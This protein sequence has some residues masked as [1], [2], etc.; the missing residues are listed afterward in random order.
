MHLMKTILADLNAAKQNDPA[1]RS[2]LEVLLFY[3]YMKALIPYRIAHRLYEKG[4]YIFARWLTN[5]GRRRSGIEI[6]PGAQIGNGFFIDHG[7]GVVIG[8]T[9]I[10]GNHVT[11]Y[12]GVTLGAVGNQTK[13]KRH[14]TVGD[15][16]LIGAGAKIL[17]DI[18]IA[19]GCKIGANAVVLKDTQPNG[20]YVGT[21]ARRV[22]CVYGKQKRD[23]KVV[24]FGAYVI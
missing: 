7:M 2:R 22:G 21:P 16:V 20:T 11:L 12:H 15:N 23:Q 5:I 3:P 9:A 1:C 24:S 17:G 6:H 8:E 18:R 4:H 14:P 13:G 19:S 10:I